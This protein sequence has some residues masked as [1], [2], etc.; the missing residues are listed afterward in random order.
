M[1]SR[2]DP[3]ALVVVAFWASALVLRAEQSGHWFLSGLAKRLI[4]EVDNRLRSSGGNA[5]LLIEGLISED[6]TVLTTF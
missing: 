5:L 3:A 4:S 2:H 1:I 6:F